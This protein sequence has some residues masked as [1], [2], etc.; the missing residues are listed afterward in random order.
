MSLSGQLTHFMVPIDGHS[1]FGKSWI[2]EWLRLLQEIGDDLRG[3]LISV[4]GRAH[5]QFAD[6]CAWRYGFCVIITESWMC[7]FQRWDFQVRHSRRF[8]GLEHR[9]LEMVL[10]R[11]E[12][13]VPEIA[14]VAVD[15]EAVE[16]PSVFSPWILEGEGLFFPFPEMLI[17]SIT[18]EER[19]AP[20]LSDSNRVTTLNK[21]TDLEVIETQGT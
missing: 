12:V 11:C 14:I 9:M 3:D 6:Q 2:I 16:A 20:L 17:N 15:L 5:R 7:F 8:G 18:L 21:S 1:E 10:C 13:L 4:W 19:F